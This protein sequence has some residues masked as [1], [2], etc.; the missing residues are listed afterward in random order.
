MMTITAR[1]DKAE[2][3]KK[4]CKDGR[5]RKAQFSVLPAEIVELDRLAREA[6]MSRDDFLYREFRRHVLKGE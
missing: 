2:A 4:R 1:W 6:K 5:T 3:R